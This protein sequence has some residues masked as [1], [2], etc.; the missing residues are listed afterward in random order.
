MYKYIEYEALPYCS[1]LYHEHIN[2]GI[3]VHVV[4]TLLSLVAAVTY[5]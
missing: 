2:S 3:H 5:F 1:D 4:H